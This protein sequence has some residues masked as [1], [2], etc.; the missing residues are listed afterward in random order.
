[1]VRQCMQHNTNILKWLQLCSSKYFFYKAKHVIAMTWNTIQMNE[2][3]EKEVV[4]I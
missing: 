2:F 1:M 3:D 4:F